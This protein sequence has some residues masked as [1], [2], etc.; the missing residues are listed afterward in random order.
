MDEFCMEFIVG[1]LTVLVHLDPV[2]E[3]ER[4]R[5][6]TWEEKYCKSSPLHHA[7]VNAI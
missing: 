4:E 6:N 2:R 1:L 7:T 3:S 5:E